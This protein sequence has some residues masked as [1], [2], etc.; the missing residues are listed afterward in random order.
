M[1]RPTSKQSW[2]V[3]LHASDTASHG[4]P[5][6]NVTVRDATTPAN[7]SR[8]GH[9]SARW[10][11]QP[12]SMKYKQ[13]PSPQGTSITLPP[14]QMHKIKTIA[15]PN[16]IKL[17]ENNCLDWVGHTL[18]HISIYLLSALLVPELRP[19]YLDCLTF[20]PLPGSSTGRHW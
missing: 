8:L 2:R 19:I 12:A 14:V 4:P 15:C 17:K 7:S 1:D 18:I 5:P 13:R 20:D 3:F 9:C 16:R 6:R 11:K 10:G